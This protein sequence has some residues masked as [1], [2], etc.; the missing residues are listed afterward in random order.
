[1]ELED[2]WEEG[3]EWARSGI[4][5]PEAACEQPAPCTQVLGGSLLMVPSS[6]IHKHLS[7]TS[8][9]KHTAML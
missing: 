6:V 7:S 8:L 9:K 1:M 5:S 3:R 4:L 2:G